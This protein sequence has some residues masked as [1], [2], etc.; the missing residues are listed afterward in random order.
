MTSPELISF[1]NQQRKLGVPDA[2]YRTALLS[3]GWENKDIDEAL[4]VLSFHNQSDN[5]IP[6]RQDQK[7]HSLLIVLQ[8]IFIL[9]LVVGFVTGNRQGYTSSLSDLI[10]FVGVILII[11]G[12]I[13]AFIGIKDAI[14][15]LK[16]KENKGIIILI[17]SLILLIVSLI[18]GYHLYRIFHSTLSF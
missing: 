12:F 8:I 7:G 9:L 6:L 2:N 1:I 15:C 10:S 14:V 17:L 18:S 16:N 13:I 11:P 3:Q 4:A 5:P